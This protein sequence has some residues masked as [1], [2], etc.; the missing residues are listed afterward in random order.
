MSK[1]LPELKVTTVIWTIIII[2]CMFYL[3]KDIIS[4][5]AVII[6]FLTTIHITADYTEE[7]IKLK[8][9]KK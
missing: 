5:V 4:V 6:L 8:E 1:D 9:A 7:R 3:G 2:A